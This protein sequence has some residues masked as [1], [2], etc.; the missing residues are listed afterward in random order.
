M[1]FVKMDF[2]IRTED[3]LALSVCE[4]YNKFEESKLIIWVF[5]KFLMII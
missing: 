1:I 5:P 2:L 3:E 4:N